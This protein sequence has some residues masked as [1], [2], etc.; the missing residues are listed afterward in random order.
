M[1]AYRIVTILLLP[2]ILCIPSLHAKDPKGVPVAQVGGDKITESQMQKDI[3]TE[4]YEAEI[5]LYKLKKSWIEQRART[6]LFEQ[7][8][9]KAG[10]SMED[11]QTQEIENK[12]VPPSQDEV[13]AVAKQIL[14]RQKTTG[15]PDEAQLAQAE[16][17][18]IGALMRR[19]IS[20]RADEIYKELVKKQPVK[21]LLKKP[22]IPKVNVT[23]S[24]RNPVSGPA[25]APITIIAFTDF[26]CS[27]C[28]RGHETMKEIAKAYP[29]KIRFVHR[30]YP[31]DSHPRAGAA[32]EAALCAGDQEQFWPYADKL[33]ANQQRFGDADFLKYAEELKLNVIQFKE[34]MSSHKYKDQIEGD[35]A[36]GKRFGV[37]GTPAFFINGR[38]VPGAQPLENF[39]EV[40]DEE[41]ARKRK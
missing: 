37:R 20:R 34:C 33:F 22:E 8:A 9:K 17:Q 2:P 31:L 35:I 25:K 1:S 32:A 30:Q 29:G 41:L 6:L 36:D 28:R 4:I 40:I 27:Y 3:G 16:T 11:W 7:A 39:A 23:F 38:L 15:Q 5:D 21:I 18:A 14:R 19:Q 26:Q 10:L 24:P 12:V 13:E